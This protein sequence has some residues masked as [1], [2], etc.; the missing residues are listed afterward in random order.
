MSP[1]DQDPARV[2]AAQ[3]RCRN[4]AQELLA[5]I[6]ARMGA[7]MPPP[8]GGAWTPADLTT[9]AAA[10][11]AQALI[12]ERAERLRVAGHVH[13]LAGDLEEFLTQWTADDLSDFGLV[14][15]VETV[16]DLLE[17]QVTALKQVRR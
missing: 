2:V 17:K 15:Q 4:P 6:R 9:A 3:A 11:M 16:I 13:N 5:E 14:Q 8:P 10:W 1:V 7:V 12:E